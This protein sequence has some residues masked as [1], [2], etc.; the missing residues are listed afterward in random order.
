MTGVLAAISRLLRVEK[1][2][3]PV[4]GAGILVGAAATGWLIRGF[5]SFEDASPQEKK[6]IL[7]RSSSDG[8]FVPI[9]L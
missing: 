3:A 6:R 9:D 5:C 4:A 7:S 1:V 8:S 2:Y